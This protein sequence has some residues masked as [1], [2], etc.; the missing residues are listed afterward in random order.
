LKKQIS[1]VLKVDVL[2]LKTN[3]YSLHFEITGT[4]ILKKISMGLLVKTIS[5]SILIFIYKTEDQIVV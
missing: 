5:E 1:I 3:L 4:F 2:M